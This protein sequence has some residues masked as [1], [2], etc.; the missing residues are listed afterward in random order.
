MNEDDARHRQ[1][2][3]IDK[4]PINRLILQRASV[5]NLS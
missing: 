5:Y 2:F 3:I 1:P 4:T